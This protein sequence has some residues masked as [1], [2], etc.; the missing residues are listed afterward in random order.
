MQGIHFKKYL[1][2]YWMTYLKYKTLLPFL[3][4]LLTEIVQTTFRNARS[5]YKHLGGELYGIW[6]LQICVESNQ[7]P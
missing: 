7:I 1:L 6:E 3:I 2:F 5:L 4:D